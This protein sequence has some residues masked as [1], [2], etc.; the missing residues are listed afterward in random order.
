MQTKVNQYNEENQSVRYTP[1]VVNIDRL[2]FF[3]FC[4]LIGN[5]FAD[6]VFWLLSRNVYVKTF[7]VEHLFVIYCVMYFQ[8]IDL[9]RKDTCLRNEYIFSRVCV[10]ERESEQFEANEVNGSC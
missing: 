4:Q 10:W 7:S 9:M 8:W 6:I 5:A 2:L 1:C 3:G